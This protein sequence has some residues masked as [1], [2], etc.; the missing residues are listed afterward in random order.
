MKDKVSIIIP[1]YNRASL[2]PRAL[3]SLLDQTY[4]PIEVFI[5]D[6]ASSDN[7][8][9][10]VNEFSRKNHDNNFEVIY[11]K[12]EKNDRNAAR[13]QAIEKASG[14]F[15][16][17]LDDDDEFLPTKLEKQARFLDQNKDVD[18]VFSNSLLEVHGKTRPF[19]PSLA[20]HDLKNHTQK[21][22][23]RQLCDGNFI[24]ITNV[25]IRAKVIKENP[26]DLELYSHEDYELWL[27]LAP[28]FRFDWIDEPLSLVHSHEHEK[29]YDMKQVCIDQIKVILKHID[30]YNEHFETLFE[31]I[32]KLKQLVASEFGDVD[33]SKALEITLSKKLELFRAAE[34][35]SKKGIARLLSSYKISKMRK[36]LK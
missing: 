8:P 27:R 13:N 6:N 3:K 30:K 19:Y 24:P 7:T 35:S 17:F 1:T 22:V 28:R 16:C 15:L 12:R 36:A 26:F 20:S 18:I 5:I 9:E 14:N 25:M 23:I 34:M 33:Y 21:E 10:V 2:L 11:I 4:R 29:R 31:K 32:I